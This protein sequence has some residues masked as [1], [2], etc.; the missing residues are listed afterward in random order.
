MSWLFGSSS[1]PTSPDLRFSASPLIN[2]QTT[3]GSTEKTPEPTPVPAEKPK[4]CCVCKTEKTAR[5]DCMLFSKSDDPQQ[6]CKSMIEQYK[7]CM[8]GYGFKV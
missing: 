6:E 1:K 5:D 4:P 2:I 3:P 8:A 7:A